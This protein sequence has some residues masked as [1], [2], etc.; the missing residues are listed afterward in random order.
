MIISVNKK[1]KTSPVK[2]AA[3]SSALSGATTSGIWHDEDSA[4]KASAKRTNRIRLTRK[5][6][7]MDYDA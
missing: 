1:T 2:Y 3:L 4:A 6:S 7:E 5:K